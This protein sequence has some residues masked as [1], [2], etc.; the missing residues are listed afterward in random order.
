MVEGLV[1]NQQLHAT[2][3]ETASG[4]Y[5]TCCTS[6]KTRVNLKAEVYTAAAN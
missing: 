5:A 4:K 6:W 3:R 1:N 2:G